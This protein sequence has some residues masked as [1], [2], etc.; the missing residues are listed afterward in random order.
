MQP[1]DRTEASAP[2]YGA[3]RVL[4]GRHGHAGK[5]GYDDDE[6]DHAVVYFGEPISSGYV[7][8]QRAHL[9]NVTS[10]EHEW[11][12]QPEVRG[13]QSNCRR[14]SVLDAGR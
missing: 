4:K 11:W 1:K 6:G 7:L 12:K 5:V 13:S 3:V 8:I 2:A 10:L 14:A 9:V